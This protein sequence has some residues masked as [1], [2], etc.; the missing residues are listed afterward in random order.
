MRLA[1]MT[2]SGLLYYGGRE[3][4]IVKRDNFPSHNTQCAVAYCFLKNNVQVLQFCHGLSRDHF[5]PKTTAKCSSIFKPRAEKNKS[6]LG[7]DRYLF[8][9]F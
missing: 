5:S 4:K 6:L 7:L 8:R 2:I 3:N 9:Y 1:I